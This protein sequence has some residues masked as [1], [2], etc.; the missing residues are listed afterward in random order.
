MKNESET[1]K[2]SKNISSY[3]MKEKLLLI[4]LK[5]DKNTLAFRLYM[6]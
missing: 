4:Y 2:Y 3:T 1:H 5:Y 6:E